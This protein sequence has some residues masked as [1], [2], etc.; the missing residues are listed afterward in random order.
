MGRDITELYS[1]Y[2]LYSSGQT[3]VTGLS[4]VSEGSVN[5]DKITRSLSS[6]TYDEKNGEKKRRS[7]VTKNGGALKN[8]KKA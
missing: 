7:P 2:L 3:T 1:D 5:H 4:A 6:E 8:I